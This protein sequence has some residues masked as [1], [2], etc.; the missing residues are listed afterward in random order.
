MAYIHCIALHW[1]CLLRLLLELKTKS[2]T[3][4]TSLN[5]KTIRTSDRCNLSH[6]NTWE[7]WKIRILI[8]GIFSSSK[9]CCVNILEYS[10][11]NKCDKKCSNSFGFIEQIY[12]YV[13]NDNPQTIVIAEFI[14]SIEHLIHW[15]VCVRICNT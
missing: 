9:K 12:I 7:Y 8:S 1:N 13:S 6:A 2:L 5:Y 15:N 4:T 11:T 10:N 14:D 3:S